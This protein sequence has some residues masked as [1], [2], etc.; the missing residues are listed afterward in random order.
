MS[1]VRN[2]A[3]R[4]SKYSDSISCRVS[5]RNITIISPVAVGVPGCRDAVT[6]RGLAIGGG[7]LG[8]RGLLDS[9]LPAS[10]A[11]HSSSLQLCFLPP[12]S[13]VTFLSRAQ[14]VTVAGPVGQ[15]ASASLHRRIHSCPP[16]PVSIGKNANS[17]L[18]CAKLMTPLSRP[19]SS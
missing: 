10:L 15:V 17:G 4:Q 1:S 14:T 19:I 11:G 9:C 13:L 12:F 18:S 5:T 3:F 2:T 7:S 16:A 8:P 6:L